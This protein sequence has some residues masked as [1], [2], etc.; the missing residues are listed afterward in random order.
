MF[1]RPHLYFQLRG[2][3]RSTP[4]RGSVLGVLATALAVGSTF[5]LPVATGGALGS[6]LASASCNP[7]RNPSNGVQNEAYAYHNVGYTVGGI[8]GNIVVYHPFLYPTGADTTTEAQELR[9]FESG[10]P[11]FAQSGW[12]ESYATGSVARPYFNWQSPD[13]SY[14][15]VYDTTLSWGGTYPFKIYYN[16]P[17]SGDWRFYADGYWYPANGEGVNLGFSPSDGRV[18]GITEDT[19]SQMPG[20]YLSPAYFTGTHL[21]YSGGWNDM[22]GSGGTTNG[23]WYTGGVSNSTQEYTYDNYCPY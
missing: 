9:G 20:G 16:N 3:V 22:G 10:G 11:Y 1:S 19:D 14:L 23:N 7:G 2:W 17:S 13:G 18:E 8:Y 4:A 15:G 6:L 21:Y 5:A 12:I